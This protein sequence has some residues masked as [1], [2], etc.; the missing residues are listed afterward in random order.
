MI[1]TTI[2]GNTVVYCSGSVYIL[3]DK[4]RATKILQEGIQNKIG[5]PVKSVYKEI[6]CS[7]MHVIAGL[8]RLTITGVHKYTVDLDLLY[9]NYVFPDKILA[10][11]RGHCWTCSLGSN[12]HI[13][14]LEH[15][16]YEHIVNGRKTVEG[17][18]YDE[19]RRK[20]GIGDCI[21]FKPVGCSKCNTLLYTVVLGLRRYNSFRE[22][23]EKEGIEHVLPDIH[24]LDEGV[25][26]YRKYYSAEDE[27]RYGV[28]A[29]EL[30]LL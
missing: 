2:E 30:G 21:V 25:K 19:K 28:V 12:L 27:E 29:I 23:L 26:V 8:N 15:K 5:A 7:N 3:Q 9:T 4:G 22:M 14:K 13:M 20:I 16:W 18:L 1:I 6:Q 10:C 11:F 17:R 24:S